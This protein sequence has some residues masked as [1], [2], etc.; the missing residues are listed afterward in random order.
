MF[1]RKIGIDLGTAN[2]LVF[3]PQKGVVI[4][5]PSVVAV[6]VE[7]NRIL[8]V[9]NEAKN[10]IGRTPDTIIAYRPLKDG[11]IADYRVTEAMLRYF[12]DKAA[13]RIRLIK[14]EVMISVPA[15]VTST[16]RRAVVEAATKAGAKAAYVVKEPVLAAIGANI[17]I[18]EP[19][20]HM[21]VDIGGGTADIAVI[22]LGGIV[23]SNSVKVAGN[24]LD[25]AIADYI[26]RHYNLAIGDRTAEDI[27]IKIG[28]AVPLE[29]DVS[30][31]IKGR[32]LLTG[33][34][35]TVTIYSSEITEAIAEPLH[36]IIQTIKRVLSDTPPE[37]AA[38]IMEQGIVMS[39]G[40]SLL[41]N[42]DQL[43]YQETGVPA[44][45]AE[46]PLLCVAKGTGI[47][48]EH[49]EVYKRSIVAKR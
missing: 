31:N 2:I 32:D 28:S 10:M 39:G 18:N 12:I 5:E 46:E 22:S 21:V 16:E 14:P 47:A 4:N 43:V 6:S 27:K 41:R 24:K 40:T 13:G 36:E 19:I 48:L 33:L 34:P 38:D 9:G 17:P 23:A 1:I 15:S 7:D 44:H 3:V 11:V 45:I 20:G 42:I 29:E 8:A 30:M 35:R 26:K 37:L 25:Q 49:L